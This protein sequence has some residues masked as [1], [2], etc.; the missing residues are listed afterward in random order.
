MRWRSNE[1]L[2]LAGLHFLSNHLPAKRWRTSAT[3]LSISEEGTEWPRP[4]IDS[5]YYHRN[6]YFIENHPMNFNPPYHDFHENSEFCL[7]SKTQS[8]IFNIGSHQKKKNNYIFTLS[9]L[10]FFKYHLSIT[11]RVA[12]GLSIPCYYIILRVWC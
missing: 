10:S 11:N 6:V 7:I 8:L 3:C 1:F 5:E 12:E 4:T 9:S 2:L